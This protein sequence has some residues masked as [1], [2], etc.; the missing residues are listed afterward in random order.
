MRTITLIGLSA[1]SMATVAPAA[2]QDAMMKTSASDARKI[3]ACS[4]MPHDKMIRNAA[5]TK[6]MKKH[7]DMLK[8]NSMMQHDSMMKAAN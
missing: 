1:L 7:P 3:E 8:H 6:L 5:C 2:A 4:A